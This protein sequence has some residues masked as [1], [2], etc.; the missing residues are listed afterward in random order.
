MNGEMISKRKRSPFLLFFAPLALLKG[1][2]WA[3]KVREWILLL[4][5]VKIKSFLFCIVLA[6]S[7]LCTIIKC[8]NDDL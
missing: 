4:D 7:Y 1:Y 5:N 3:N 2:G 6:S 8:V